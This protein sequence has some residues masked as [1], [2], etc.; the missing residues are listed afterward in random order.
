MGLLPFNVEL[1]HLGTSVAVDGRGEGGDGALG[2]VDV[3]MLDDGS[4]VASWLQADAGGRGSLVLRRVTPDGDVGSPVPVAQGA[5]GR[6]VPQMAIK[7]DD[8]VLVWTE[9]HEERKSIVSA[10]IPIDSVTALD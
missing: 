1:A 2:H 4:A 8:L 10:R 9:A 3:V 7:G 6:S 5:P